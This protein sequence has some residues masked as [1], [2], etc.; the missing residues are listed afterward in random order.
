MPET[1]A[2][3][4]IQFDAAAHRYAIEQKLVPVHVTG[5]L[6]SFGFI[7]YSGVPR[8]T[9]ERKQLIG[10]LVHRIT[11]YIDQDGLSLDLALGMA[12]D[13]EP[14]LC[15]TYEVASTDVSP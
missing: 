2:T 15:L 7:N 13:E 8:Y 4:T 9:L 5:I 12:L 11:S 3:P 6:E 10:D 14:D 1:A